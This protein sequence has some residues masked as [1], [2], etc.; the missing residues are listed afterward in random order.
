MTTKT[1]LGLAIG[2]ALSSMSAS[3]AWHNDQTNFATIASE[4]VIP[5]WTTTKTGNHYA[6]FLKA[7]DW[8]N[9]VYHGYDMYLQRVNQKGEVVWDDEPLLVIDRSKSYVYDYSIAALDNESVRIAI[10]DERENTDGNI[11]D[12]VVIYEVSAD[13]KS[14]WETGIE[15]TS[16]TGL[17]HVGVPHVTAV[18][19]GSIVTWDESE[20]V[21]GDLDYYG[22]PTNAHIAYVD[23]NGE[24]KW[25]V[26]EQ[27]HDASYPVERALVSDGF[28]V[29]YQDIDP[30]YGSH[31]SIQKYSLENG[32]PTWGDKP[33][34]FTKGDLENI[35]DSPAPNSDITIDEHENVIIAW[36]LPTDSG[37]MLMMQEFDR[38]GN[39]R[40]SGNLRISH[41]DADYNPSGPSIEVVNGDRIITFAVLLDG[42]TP[43]TGIFAQK[44][45]ADGKVIWSEPREIVQLTSGDFDTGFNGYLD[46][47]NTSSRNG[48]VN[49]Y[50]MKVWDYWPITYNYVQ[51]DADGKAGEEKTIDGNKNTKGNLQ[52]HTNPIGDVIYWSED[53]TNNSPIY[54]QNI[55]ND[56]THGLTADI[57][58]AVKPNLATLEDMSKVMTFT[59]HD[60]TSQNHDVQLTT[61]TTDITITDV[62]KAATHVSA[63]IT[64]SADYIGEA[65]FTLAVTDLDNSSRSATQN[66]TLN[67]VTIDDAPEIEIASNIEVF[68]GESTTV[69]A[70]VTDVD[71]DD[72]S[73]NWTHNS[74]IELNVFWS[75]NELTVSAPLV[76]NTQSIELTGTLDDGVNTVE[77]TVTVKVNKVESD[78]GSALGSLWLFALLGLFTRKIKK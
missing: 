66:Y 31:L 27:L 74:D 4:G 71:S 72:V 44:V 75:N 65:T 59:I 35:P 24:I 14:R 17:S 19:N 36:R 61:E 38:M 13:K 34:A 5:Q 48:V 39:K 25:H 41:G 26:H 22:D 62:V 32:E 56:G 33:V 16:P 76:D 70:V 60:E 45:S 18:G 23:E 42:S 68:E 57:K 49:A 12:V 55:H 3:A 6:G 46:V 47:V 69:S 63:T 21:N 43:E 40:F 2:L 64:P 20:D 7:D 10:R 58:L 50:F 77:K 1:Q 37:A 28:I 29:V 15:I 11:Q 67:V 73:V 53:G 30:E 52:L 54:A 8:E 51:F 9:S 78:A